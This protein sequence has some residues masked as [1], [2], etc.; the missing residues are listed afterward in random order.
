MRGRGSQSG[1]LVEVTAEASLVLSGA[2]GLGVLLDASVRRHGRGPKTDNEAISCQYKW[3]CQTRA[4]VLLREQVSL[5]DAAASPSSGDCNA[6]PSTNP[7]VIGII[8][9]SASDARRVPVEMRRRRPRAD[10]NQ[11]L[12]DAVVV[13]VR[14]RA[15]VPALVPQCLL[16]RSQEVLVRREEV[17][18]VVQLASVCHVVGDKDVVAGQGAWELVLGRLCGSLVKQ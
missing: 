18:V 8:Q 5:D 9:I 2:V 7:L 11:I 4:D 3:H 1:G 13:H 10:R 17:V 15:L 12:G 6:V 14:L 16:E